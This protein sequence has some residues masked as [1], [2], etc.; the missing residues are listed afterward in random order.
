MG[1]TIKILVV[2]GLVVVV[3][4]AGI[5]F[6]TDINQYKDQIVQVVKDN[7]GR[8]FEISGD[9]KL[10]P[11]LIPTIAVEGV[12]LG[13][14][15]WA[16]EKN[17]LS[18][19]KFEAQIALMP[20]LKKNI[21]VI[22][23]ILIEPSIHLETNSKG[24]GNWVLATPAPKEKESIAE[25][26]PASLP[27]LA[28][29]EVHI[30]DAIISYKDGK[31]G[32]TT[33]LHIDEVS[34]NSE[35][36]SDPMKLFVKAEVNE[37]PLELTGSLGSINS[38]LDNKDYSI[39]INADIAGAKISIE[40]KLG[41][42]MNAKGIDLL[43]SLD[44]KELS[45]LNKLAGAELPEAGP[46][47]LSGKLSDTKSGYSVKS[48]SAQVM[49]YKVNGDIEIALSGARPKLMASL[50]T[51]SLDVSPFQGAPEEGTPKKEKLFPSDPLPLD[52]LKSADVDLKFKAKKLIT[53]DLTI[54]DVNLALTLNNGKLQIT[55]NSKA[56]GGT[57][58]VDIS[59]DGSNAKSATLSNNI[60]L[61][62]IEL[63]QLP[64]IKE[65]EIL[66]GGKS[67]ITIKT[68]GSGASV[69]AIMA[70]LNGKLLITVGAGK[71]SSKVMEL[72]SADAL[73]STLSMINPMAKGSDGS[74]L[75]CAV[76]NFG[77]TNG[78][79]TAD[80][81]IAMST[82]QI[83]II[84]GGNINLKTETLD[85]GI[86]P[87]EKEGVGLNVAQLAALVR[88]GGTLASPTPKTDTKAALKKGLSAGA[89]VAT[90]GL[91]LLAGELLDSGSGD[92]ANPCDIALGKVPKTPVKKP[93]TEKNTVEKT[94]DTVKDAASAVGDK[95]KNLF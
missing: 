26:A 54:D 44:I 51:D 87:K 34:V 12:S 65:K 7:T 77:I 81:G 28:V 94:A 21:Q 17:M 86:T 4:L 33:E 69:S 46:I 10:A 64:A 58:S 49:E 30:K 79:A 36:F 9:L 56:V 37:S 63:G 72:A 45:S 78:I 20:L 42:P 57:I 23:F 76:I 73:M 38:L 53:K 90:G 83:N 32:E 92:D 47:L 66:T 5:I 3:A 84:G 50:S 16:K 29:N 14:A 31:T 74:L 85:I 82:N 48:M 88:L 61:K 52:G 71:I 27:G 91:S 68:N 22:K 62:Q 60:E 41:Q 95:L 89:A 6:T 93:A 70:S 1:K 40:G 18:V 55:Q 39:N 59:L 43:A 24:E 11:S 67:N 13:N 15:S 8:D 2:L 19:S 35:S 80:N 75:E 25:T